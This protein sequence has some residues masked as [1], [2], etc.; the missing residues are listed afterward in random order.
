MEYL[1][2]GGLVAM[3]IADEQNNENVSL[4]NRKRR[5]QN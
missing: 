2:L 5:A 4:K 1:C 3:T